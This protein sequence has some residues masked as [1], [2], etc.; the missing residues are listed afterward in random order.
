[1]KRINNF[2]L[3]TAIGLVGLLSCGNKSH[4]GAPANESYSLMNMSTEDIKDATLID[5]RT[6]EARNVTSQLMADEMRKIRLAKKQQRMSNAI[7]SRN[8]KLEDVMNAEESLD[9]ALKEAD[10][11][12]ISEYQMNDN[13]AY[14]SIYIDLYQDRTEHTEKISHKVENITPYQPG[15]GSNAID[16]LSSGWSAVCI[17]F[18][19]LINIWPLYI[20]L[21]IAFFIYIRIRKKENH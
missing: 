12:K 3:V 18:L 5:Y 6:V 21:G 13:I 9:N 16:A 17:L 8:G 10:N 7:G 14:S 15:F 1:M 19:F 4:K 2:I 11:T 20:L